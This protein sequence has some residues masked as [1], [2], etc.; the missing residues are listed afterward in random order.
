MRALVYSIGFA[1]ASSSALASAQTAPD[2]SALR[3]SVGDR[4]IITDAG[5]V[6]VGGRVT[7]LSPSALSIDGYSFTP[8]EAV[9]VE[10]P[11]DPVWDGAA[12]GYGVGALFGLTI[13]AEGCLHSAV[14]RCVNAG[15]ITYGLL[16]ALIDYAHK[17][18]QDDLPIAVG[19]A[20]QSG[21]ARPRRRPGTKGRRGRARVLARYFSFRVAGSNT[22]KRYARAGKSTSAP[23]HEDRQAGV[24]SRQARRRFAR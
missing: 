23:T 8:G 16:G 7:A 21:A 15:G 10:R 5:G 12:I 11:G 13:G 6:E 17:G 14:W 24:A 4:V 3:A 22:E 18:A 19:R 20:A 2:F 1:V 9:K